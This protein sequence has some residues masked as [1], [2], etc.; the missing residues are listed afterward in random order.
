MHV[1]QYIKILL[2]CPCVRDGYGRGRY[3]FAVRV[4]KC[5]TCQSLHSIF[6]FTARVECSRATSW[7]TLTVLSVLNRL[8]T[9]L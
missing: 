1:N 2:V 8:F 9:D 3:E 4:Q 6:M 5:L 7:R